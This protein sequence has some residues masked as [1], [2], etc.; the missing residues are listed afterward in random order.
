MNI[1]VQAQDISNG[2]TI[3]VTGSGIIS[4]SYSVSGVTVLVGDMSCSNVGIVATSP[5]DIIN[6]TLTNYE[7]DYYYV[8]VHVDNKGL[9]SVSSSSAPGPLR[10]ASLPV[11]A[12]PSLLLQPKISSVDPP[13]GSLQGG[14]K[15][16]VI[17]NGFSVISTRLQVTIGECTCNILHTT[18]SAITCRI[19]CDQSN[20]P[21]NGAAAVAI[22]IN[23]YDVSGEYFTFSNMATPM[24][25]QVVPPDNGSAISAGDVIT[26]NGQ[27]LDGDTVS[28]KLV[29]IAAA[30][31][32]SSSLLCEII[33]TS[34]AQINCTIPEAAAGSYEVVVLADDKGYSIES[35]ASSAMIEYALEVSSF[36]PQFGG[37]GGGLPLTLYGSGFPAQYTESDFQIDLCGKVC[38][39]ISSSFASI[40]CLTPEMELDINLECVITVSDNNLNQIE[41]A[42]PFQYLDTSTPQI[43]HFTPNRGGTAGGTTLTIYGSRFL[44]DGVTSDALSEADLTVNVGGVLCDWINQAVTPNDSVIQ[45]RTSEHRT[46]LQA[47]VTVFVGGKGFAFTAQDSTFEYIDRWSSVFTWGGLDPPREGESVYIKSGQTVLLDIDTPKLNLIVIEGTLVFEDE[48]DIHLKAKYIFINGGTLQASFTMFLKLLTLF[49]IKVKWSML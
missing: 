43:S 26:I 41:L 46:T 32:Q 10:N 21:S 11:S 33:A 27:N 17:G 24:V 34:E 35:S 13:F 4:D 45:C 42:D 1:F 31:F 20:L 3:T 40:T 15:V 5:N 29:S 30:S 8:D 44:P 19:E 14:T 28:V 36:S 47:S 39:I 25:D 48:H 16:E 7:A 38:T 9:A 49:W 18:F 12:Y 37:F 2:K 22:S 6:C 23:G